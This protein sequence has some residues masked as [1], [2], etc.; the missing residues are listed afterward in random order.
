MSSIADDSVKEVPKILKPSNTPGILIQIPCPNISLI[1]PIIKRT[2]VNPIPAPSP[3]I[4]ERCTG[5]LKAN[6]SALPRIPQFT[7]IRGT[8]T[9][10]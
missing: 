2:R 8:N 10:N 7:T 1:V 3:S 5:F 6:P 4:K 9:P